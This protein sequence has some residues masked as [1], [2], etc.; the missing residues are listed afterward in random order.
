MTDQAIVNQVESGLD[1]LA[2]RDYKALH[3]ECIAAIHKDPRNAA[4]FLL[5]GQL[6]SDHQNHH[7]ALELFAKS[8]DLAP[9][10]GYCSVYYAQG[11][12][13]VGRQAEAKTMADH[14]S[15][16]NVDN[17]HLNDTLGVIYSRT[18]FHE[19]AIECFKRAVSFNPKPANYHYNLGASLQFM[20]NFDSA[21]TAYQATLDRDKDDYRALA[22]MVSLSKQTNENHQLDSLLALYDQYLNNTDATLHLGHAIA[23]TYEDLG[24]YQTSLRWLRKA[25]A[26]KLT[27]GSLFNF[28]PIFAAA[29]TTSVQTAALSERNAESPIFVVGLPRTGTTLVDRILSSHPDVVAAGELNAFAGLIKQGTS[30]SSNLMMDA[31]TL[32]ATRDIDMTAIGEQYI[33]AT[34]ELRRGAPR[35]TDKMPLN[36]FYAGLIH[37]AL[38]NAK[39]VVLRR[40]AMDSCLSNYRQLLTAQDAYYNYTYCLTTTATF[41]RGFDDLMH[42]WRNTLPSSCFIE[43]HYEDIVHDQEQQTRRLLEFCNLSWHEGCLDFHRNE[44]PVSTASSVQVRQPLYSGSIGRWKRY[45]NELDQLKSDLGDLVMG[46]PGDS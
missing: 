26:G 13:Q 29:K 43:V 34:N 14:A 3:A 20:G 46:S 44:A 18:G 12:T 7:K 42:H 40:G 24:E 25:K 6:A 28:E 2:K 17:A 16:L 39:I 36:F 41:Y 32:S 15:S 31:D 10:N 35:F 45:G 27:Q 22:S 37:Q 38:P 4:P 11:L 1:R 30:S 33:Q 21:K 8:H 5:L 9:N 23:K 19:K